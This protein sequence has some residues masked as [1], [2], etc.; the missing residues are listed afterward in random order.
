MIVLSVSLFLAALKF[1][2][3]TPRGVICAILEISLYGYQILVLHSYVESNKQRQN[4]E[5]KYTPPVNK[6]EASESE[7]PD[8]IEPRSDNFVPNIE[9]RS[10]NF[11]PRSLPDNVI[12]SSYSIPSYIS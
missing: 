5:V 7:A 9:P 1:L 3:F 4:I 2:N 8:H 11:V 6:S 12:P 10:D